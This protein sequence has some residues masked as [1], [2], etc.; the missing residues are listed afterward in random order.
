VITEYCTWYLVLLEAMASCI[1]MCSSW[2]LQKERGTKSLIQQT[3]TF[4]FFRTTVGR[5]VDPRCETV[6]DCV[7]IN[8]VMMD[9]PSVIVL[10][11]IT[12]NFIRMD[13]TGTKPVISPQDENSDSLDTFSKPRLRRAIILKALESKSEKISFQIPSEQ[14]DPLTK[15]Y[16][17]IHSHGLLEFLTTSWSSW[18]ALGQQGRDPGASLD[19]GQDGIK[20]LILSSTSLPRDSHQQPSKNVMGQINYYCTDTCT[21]IMET[22]LDELKWDATIVKSAVDKSIEGTLV[23]AMPTH[24][25]H[26]AA[27]D[28]FGGY[29]YL[30]QAAL[31][32]RLFQ[33]KH[34]FSKVAVLDIGE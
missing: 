29:C 24:P 22:L 25:G 31:A 4:K 11:P 12:P 7:N 9:D 18:E 2:A 3:K 19:I 5:Q 20:S 1:P 13:E 26:H 23:Y 10:A 17:D 30:N 33:S 27:K 16:A 8:L 21:P 34:N 32:A 14:K 6:N 15:V 28:S